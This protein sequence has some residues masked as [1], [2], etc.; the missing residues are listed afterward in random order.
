MKQN[1][2]NCRHF[3]SYQTIYEDELED[4]GCGECQNPK[5]LLFHEFV[6]LEDSCGSFEKSE[7]FEN[8]E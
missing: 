2:E 3:I 5:G 4:Y 8:K 7:Y 6:T 1:C